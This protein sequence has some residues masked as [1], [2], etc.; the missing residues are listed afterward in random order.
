[1]AAHTTQPIR[2]SIE[3]EYWVIDEQGELV[4]PG[5]LVSASGRAEREFVRPLL[6]VKTTPCETTSQ[7]RDELFDQLEAVLDRAEESGKRLVPL[8]TP[9]AGSE[10][11]EIPSERTRIQNEVIGEDF[12]YVRHCA[13]THVHVEQQPGH[14]VDQWNAFVAL[15]PAL[16]LVNS[17]PY[18][19]GERLAAGA[20]SKLYRRRAY[21]GMPHQG[22]LWSYIDDKAEWT[23]RLERRYEDFVTA[24]LDADVDRATVEANFDPESAVWTPVQFRERFGTVEWR[25]ADAAL[26]GQVLRLADQ[27]ADVAASVRDGEVRIE[28]E[29]G[30]RTEEGLVLPSFDTVLEYVD[31]AIEDG[32]DSEQVRGYLERMG[33]DVAA[34]DPLTEHVDDGPTISAEAARD[35]RLEYA[36]VLERAVRSRSID[37]NR[38]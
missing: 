28:G 21:D 9:M 10:V 16:A 4:E 32:L 7:L 8:A 18:Y 13:G 20:R 27:L 38:L 36:D 35:R 23:R 29:I 26:P 33:F 11:D 19:R 3:V 30:R 17:S 6:E 31:A 2:R 37:V 5:E 22:R 25:S 12:G 14:E 15:D 24:T 1:M 34:Y